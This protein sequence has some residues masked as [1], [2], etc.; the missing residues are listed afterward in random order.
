[1]PR[2]TI[3]LLCA[4]LIVTFCVKAQDGGGSGS[5]SEGDMS[6]DPILALESIQVTVTALSETTATHSTVSLATA[7]ISPTPDAASVSSILVSHSQPNTVTPAQFVTSILPETTITMVLKTTPIPSVT[8]TMSSLQINMATTSASTVVLPASLSSPTTQE[9]PIMATDS[10]ESIL[11]TPGDTMSA[12]LSS[13]II[14]SSEDRM[15]ALSLRISSTMLL[16]STP[17]STTVS[18]FTTPHIVFSTSQRPVSTVP[19]ATI[20]PTTGADQRTG[21]T[22]SDTP[23]DMV[24]TTTETEGDTTTSNDGLSTNEGLSISSILLIV[25]GNIS[26]LIILF[27]IIICVLVGLLCKSSKGN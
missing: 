19:S 9:S 10:L 22:T 7:A 20:V 15:M 2:E 16:T 14:S 24:N 1:M 6:M 23:V 3:F 18:S 12:T 13:M 4:S 8:G 21:P 11:N 17:G 25:L 27:F 26:F 5:G